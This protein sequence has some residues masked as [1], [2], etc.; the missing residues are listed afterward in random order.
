LCQASLGLHAGWMRW[1][2]PRSCERPPKPMLLMPV[3]FQRWRRTHGRVT[4]WGYRSPA[5]GRSAPDPMSRQRHCRCQRVCFIV[6]PVIV[7]P[8]SEAAHDP[9]SFT[10]TMQTRRQRELQHKCVRRQLFVFGFL[11]RTAS[12]CA[13][14]ASS[15]YSARLNG[16]RQPL[17]GDPHL[18]PRRPL[19]LSRRRL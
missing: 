19:D 3:R 12:M 1:I 18:S 13:S 11:P 15:I 17:V 7:T 16:T 14:S 8:R 6:A 10:D 2:S 5:I 4:H 9:K